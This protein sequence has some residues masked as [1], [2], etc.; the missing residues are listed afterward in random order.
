M[1]PCAGSQLPRGRCRLAPGRV[2][3]LRA[4]PGCVRPPRPGSLI[5]I[6]AAPRRFSVSEAALHGAVSR[7]QVAPRREHDVAA[8]AGLPVRLTRHG[9][10]PRGQGHPMPASRR[11]AFGGN[12]P[13]RSAVADPVPPRIPS[14]TGPAGGRARPPRRAAQPSGSKSRRKAASA[15]RRPSSVNSTDL[16]FVAGSEMRPL[17]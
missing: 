1:D 11:H 6:H 8:V 2:R 14:L 17:T 9:Q 13:D 16:A 5:G 7:Q 3:R 12:R 4:I 10:C 15:S